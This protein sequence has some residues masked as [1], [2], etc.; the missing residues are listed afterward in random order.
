M[1][2]AKTEKRKFMFNFKKVKL[3]LCVQWRHTGEVGVY[4]HSFLTLA[5]AG[6]EQ[7]A[8]QTHC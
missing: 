1:K 4:L 2:R 7:S 6:D 8:E 5:L 3:S